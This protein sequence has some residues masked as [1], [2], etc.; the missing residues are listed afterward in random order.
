MVRDVGQGTGWEWGG[1]FKKLGYGTVTT[2]GLIGSRWSHAAELCE[3]LVA[4]PTAFLDLHPALLSLTGAVGF[5]AES[6]LLIANAPNTA[7]V[8]G[9]LDVV[10]AEPLIIA[11][12]MDDAW[13]TLTVFGH[14]AG[15]PPV[16]VQR[17]HFYSTRASDRPG[18]LSDRLPPRSWRPRRQHSRPH[19][20]PRQ[21]N[22]PRS[23]PPDSRTLC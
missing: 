23:T 19:P 9:V 5:G 21:T 17:I 22:S 15:D 2:P 7:T 11:I 8:N 10:G 18:R 12:R 4:A 14:E 1:R 16:E 20:C 6:H 3:R 13:R